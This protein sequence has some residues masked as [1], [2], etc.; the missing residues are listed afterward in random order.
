M[1][2]LL[3][4]NN[5]IINVAD[6]R[7][8][9][10]RMGRATLSRQD[11]HLSE[12]LEQIPV[13][14]MRTLDDEIIPRLV[15]SYRSNSPHQSGGACSNQSRTG[16]ADVTE[17][18]N[19]LMTHD[20]HEISRYLTD[21]RL[22]GASLEWLCMDLMSPAAQHVGYLWEKDLCSIID[23]TLAVGRLQQIL[24]E[25]SPRHESYGAFSDM[26]RR[27]LLL[28]VPGEQH[29]FGL[30]LITEFFQQA[31]WQLWGWPLLEDHDLIALVRQEW[32]AIIGISVSAEVNL[33]GL[34][35]LIRDL[36]RV[37]GNPNLCVMV[38]GPV[39]LKQP[40][41]V[42]SVGADATAVDAKQAV[43]HAESLLHIQ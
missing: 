21:L 14:I 4:R 24:R 34:A 16:A 18:A 38:G 31:G 26:R 5:K 9:N 39:F 40:Q 27:A 10:T 6:T 11:G 22:R 3:Q 12:I 20:V 23:V 32:L 42:K 36:R 33:V 37:S 15:L 1:A 7:R 30:S 8:D 19:L 13:D 25:L 28:P 17:F 43:L 29:T 35:A 2:G 41:L